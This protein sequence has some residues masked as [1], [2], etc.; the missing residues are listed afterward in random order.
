MSNQIKLKEERYGERRFLILR[1]K[2][3]ES[4]IEDHLLKLRGVAWSGKRKCLYMERCKNDVNQIYRHLKGWGYF[5]D[6]SDLKKDRKDS[7]RG[8]GQEKK[9]ANIRI[10]DKLPELSVRHKKNLDFFK[11]WMELKHYS[12]NTINTYIHM[13]T[14]FFRYYSNKDTDSISKVDIERFNYKFVVKNAYS[15]TFQNQIISALKLYYLKVHKVKIELEQIER[16]RPSRKLP[17]VIP[18]KDVKKLLASVKNLKHKTAL[19][20]IYSLGL[21]RS[22]LIN[23]KLADINL[24]REVVDIR[25]AK[26]KKDRTIPL[27]EKLKELIIRYYKTYL[28]EVWV[29]EGNTPSTQYSET[30]LQNIFKNNLK[31]VVKNHTFTLHSLRHSYATHLHESG[32]DIRNIQELLGHKSSKTTE[33]YTHVSIRSLKNISNP[34]DDF[35]I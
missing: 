15:Y 31:R 20:M 5:L 33:I 9:K 4:F 1:I 26:G 17:K 22:E 14:L 18:Q 8:H 10:K 3:N 29:I 25:N 24:K 19:T 30:S 27:P 12:K 35:D 28:P 6:Y 16:P 13:L 7:G 34:I 23:L 32:V 21:R 2:G 11:K